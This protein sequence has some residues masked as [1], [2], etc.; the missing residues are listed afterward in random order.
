MKI[1]KKILAVGSCAAL[2]CGCLALTA[3]GGGNADNGAQKPAANDTPKAA[4]YKL[5]TEGTITV[6]TSAD[7]PPMEYMDGDEIK[8][9]DPALMQ[10]I[11][12]RLGLKIE[13]K[14]QAFDSLV[15]AV[16]G[17]SSCDVA[18]SAI[19]IDDERAEQVDFSE[20]YYDSNLAI[21]VMADSKFEKKGEMNS[22][23]VAVGAQS[24]SSGEAWAKENLKKAG[25]T[26]YQETPD[27]LQA[28]RTGKIDCA[29]YDDP[30]AQAH[31][32]GEYKDMRILDVIPTGEQ[33]G[34][35]V[36]KDNAA[37]TEA[38]NGALKEIKDDGTYAKLVKK[39]LA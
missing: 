31:V 34:I 24:G 37:L 6:A 8:G 20:S 23:E 38:I 9:F 26:P 7:Y 33:Y 16:A 1:S 39:Y 30:V 17:G 5:L 18:I 2:L 10:E 22:D 3:C 27:L 4:D 32:A 15:T 25:Y 28:L 14:N 13:L 29:V 35:I 12:D 11:G 19:T 36:N 21:V